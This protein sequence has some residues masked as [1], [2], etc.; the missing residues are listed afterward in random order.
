MYSEA[1]AMADM[2]GELK[3]TVK[4]FKRSMKRGLKVGRSRNLKLLYVMQSHLCSDA[5]FN[6][7]DFLQ[8]TNIFLGSNIP[9]VLAT[10]GELKG[11]FSDDK[12]RKLLSEFQ[13][14]SAKGERY[15]MLVVTANS[16]EA[17][18]MIPPKPNCLS[19]LSIRN[20]TPNL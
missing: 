18:I 4:T 2:G 3:N 7:A 16:R 14:L 15:I 13:S 11:R 20:F 6:T 5:G 1:L 17:F 12:R 8:S 10:D 19:L 9:M